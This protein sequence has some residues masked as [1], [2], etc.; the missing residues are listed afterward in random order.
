MPDI[1]AADFCFAAVGVAATLAVAAQYTA[2]RR[3]G[4]K[5]LSP[6]A[7]AVGVAV[8]LACGG[9]AAQVRA[10]CEG[11]P[12]CTAWLPMLGLLGGIKVRACGCAEASG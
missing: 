11:L 5:A 2:L 3:P 6:F 8:A 4:S 10:A 12:D 7:A 1:S 9:G